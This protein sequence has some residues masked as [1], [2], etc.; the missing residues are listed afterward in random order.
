MRRKGTS[1]QLGIVRNVGLGLLGQGKKPKEVAEILNVTSRCVRRWRQ[2]SKQPKRKK[3]TAALGRPRKI[4]EK[5]VKKLEKALDQGAFAFGYAGDYWTLDRIAQI[6]WQLFKVRYHPSAVW[7]VMDRMGWSSQRPQRR[8][9]HRN[10][11]AIE[12]WKKEVLP[13]IKKRLVP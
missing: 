11:E 8:A 5:Q 1:E 2:E 7:H 9:F 10:E 4:T 13:E 6:I 3:A 12:K